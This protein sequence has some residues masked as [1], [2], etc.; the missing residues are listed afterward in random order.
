M[1]IGPWQIVLIIAII[2]IFFGPKRIPGLGKS[3]GEGIRGFKKGLGDDETEANSA[4]LE[5]KEQEKQD[6]S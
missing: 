2:L 1:S 5:G 6:N 3:I 4:K